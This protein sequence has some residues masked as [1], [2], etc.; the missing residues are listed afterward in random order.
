MTSVYKIVIKYKKILIVEKESVFNFIKEIF[1][2]YNKKIDFLMIT[3]KG[4]PCLNTLNFIN[5]IKNKKIRIFGLFD[6]DPFGLD[7]SRI[8]ETRIN[9]FKYKRIGITMKD[10]RKYKYVKSDAINLTKYDISK[11]KSLEKLDQKK[12]KK[13]LNFLLRKKKCEIEIFT[14]FDNKFLIK[15]LSKKMKLRIKENFGK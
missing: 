2:K 13:D 7:I 12:L 14:T 15:Y 10:L 9:N 4:Y 11:I 3:G 6:F 5:K 8:Y 1:K